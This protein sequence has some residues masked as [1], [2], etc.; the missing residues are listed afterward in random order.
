M[1]TNGTVAL[2]M[3]ELISALA[4]CGYSEISKPNIE[5]TIKDFFIYPNFL[6]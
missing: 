5:E 6:N 2:S 3:N 1:S 4:L